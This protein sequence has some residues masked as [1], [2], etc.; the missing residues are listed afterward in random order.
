MHH[1][2]CISKINDT[3]IDHTED[4][5]IV[6][7]MYNLTEYSKNYSKTSG[8]LWNYHRDQPNS[9]LGG[10]D[11]NI[12]YSIKDSKSFDYKTSITGKLEDDNR[13]KK[14]LKLL[15]HYSISATFGGLLHI[16]LVNCAVSI[17]LAWSE[18]CLLTSKAY[19][20]AVPAQGGNPAVVGINNPTNATFKITVT[21]LYVPVVT[22]STENNNKLLE[23]L[24]TEFKRTI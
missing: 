11:N 18:N 12:N 19:R 23:Q 24:K 15:C 13:E 9:G 10:E 6:I 1:L 14:M 5:D 21:K 4:L 17:I 20:R 2:F 16:P 3:L 22:L 7:S 8:T